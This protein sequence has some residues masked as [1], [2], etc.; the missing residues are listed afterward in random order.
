MCRS[1]SV[2]SLLFS[3]RVYVCFWIF[4]LKLLLMKIGKLLSVFGMSVIIVKCWQIQIRC[5][6]VLLWLVFIMVWKWIFVWKSGRLLFLFRLGVWVVWL[7][8]QGWVR[9]GVLFLLL[10]SF[11]KMVG[12]SGFFLCCLIRFINSLWVS[13]GVYCC[14][15]FKM[16]CIILVKCI[17]KIFWRRGLCLKVLLF[18]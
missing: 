9:F 6:L 17:L 2:I 7:M 15:F 5:L 3:R 12:V 10:C 16:I 18:F 8:G 14:I 13:V 1:L 4:W 11:L